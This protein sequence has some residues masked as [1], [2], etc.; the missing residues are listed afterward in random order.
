MSKSFTGILLTC[1]LG[2]C[3]CFGGF[4]D[5]QQS[6]SPSTAKCRPVPVS[7]VRLYGELGARYMAA[8][9]NLLTRTD[10]YSE[11]SFIASAA[12]HPGAFWWDWPGDQIGRWLSVLHVAEG[13]GWTPAVEQRRAVAEAVLPHQTKEGNFGPP[14]SATSDDIKLLSGNCFA[15]R[16]LMDAYADTHDPRYLDAA[17]KMG[18]YFEKLAPQWETRSE[19]KLHEFYGHCL[20]GL[21]ALYE[22]GGDR[23]AL[24]LAERIAPHAGRTAHAHHSLSLCRGLIDLA[25]LTGKKE[26]LDKVED[27]LAWCRESQTATGGLPEMMPQHSEDEGC[28]LADWVVVNLM[29]YQATGQ[30]RYLDDAEHT[31]V[32]H[33]FFNQF[34]TGG[35]GHL[36]YSQEIVGGKDWQ[37]WEGQ[38]GSENPGCCSLWGQWGLGQTGSYIVTQTADAVSVNLYPSAEINLPERGVQLAISSDFPRMTKACLLVKCDK[39]QSFSL[40]LRIPTWTRS[41]RVQCD[42]SPVETP[43]AGRRVVLNRTWKGT[44]RI[45]ITFENELRTVSWPLKNPKGTAVFDGPLCLGLSSDSADVKLPWAVP[46]DAAGRPIPDSQGRPQVINPADG[47]S[48]TLEPINSKW[49]TPEVKNPARWRVLFQT[50]NAK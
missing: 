24:D 5:A 30:E 11:D 45:D 48:K 41:M 6:D 39:P 29:M 14:A 18:R 22:Q 15:L 28:T 4:S 34:H 43:K 13:Y 19:G 26:Y 17:R 20:D 47:T 16:G 38:F 25:L 42:G 1:L 23:W 46:L 8:T 3:F 21:V 12:G 9:C 7:Q 31:L 49:L 36:G 10:R 44:T 27:Y 35:F 50:K 33:F 37:G 2:C 32:N 40:A